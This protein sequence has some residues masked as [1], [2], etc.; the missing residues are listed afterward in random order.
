MPH[1]KRREADDAVSAGRVKVNG[2][3]VRPSLRVRSGDV[4]GR[5]TLNQVDP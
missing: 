4:V 1:L 3:L 2:E 5:C